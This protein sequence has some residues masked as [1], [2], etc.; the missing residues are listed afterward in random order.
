MNVNRLFALIAALFFV[1]CSSA[2]PVEE[3]RTIR[4]DEINANGDLRLPESVIPRSYE[5]DLTLIPTADQ[6][7]AIASI[8]FEVTEAQTAIYMH[9]RDLDMQVELMKDGAAIDVEIVPGVN[10]GFALASG[11]PFEPGLYRA[12][13]TY[14]A[15]L[16]DTPTGLYRVEDDEAQYL[17][18]QFQPLEA[19]SVFPGFDEPKF[20]AT[21]ETTLRVP[22]GLMAVTNTPIK[23]VENEAD[24]DVYRFAKTPPLP[25]YLVAFAVG[26]FEEA[27]A[28]EEIPGVPFRILTPQGKSHLA[29]FMLEKTPEIV[30]HQV[31]Y[32]G[33]EF[34]YA[35]L[36]VVA[37]PNFSAGAMENVGL[38]TF[39]ERLLLLDADTASPS[40]KRAAISVMAHEIAH[41]WF[42]NYVTLPWWDDLWLN[43][44]FA[45]WMALKVL[46]DLEPEL[47]GG[48]DFTRQ[49]AGLTPLDSS[50]MSRAIRQPIEDSGDVYNAFDPL[51]Y[52]KGASLLRMVEA[53]IGEDAMRSGVRTYVDANP[54]GTGST[55]ELFAALDEASGQAV[56]QTLE[57]F[58][59]QPGK[60]LL[61]VELECDDTPR[62][63]VSQQRYLPAGSSA[64]PGTPW[65]VPM[66]IRYQ[67]GRKHSVHCEV[68][69]QSS[70]SIE[71]PTKR[72]PGWI[73]PNADEAGYY[74]WSL[75]EGALPELAGP[76]RK[77]LNTHEMIGLT[78]SL[79]AL[80]DAQTID[81]LDYLKTVETLGAV[82][83]RVVFNQVLSAFYRVE[84][85]LED[86][87]P[88]RKGL[89][90]KAQKLISKRLKRL[91][92]KP[93]KDE[94]SQD[95][96][97]RPRLIR[98]SAQLADNEA[99]L[100]EIETITKR[101]L[102]RMNDVEPEIARAALIVSASTSGA[103]RWLSYKMALN[104]APTPAA[105]SAILSGL[106]GFRDP[107]IQRRTLGLLLDGTIKSQDFW[108]VFGPMFRREDTREVAWQWL[109]ENYDAV[110]EQLGAMSARSLVN[111]A[112]AFCTAD[113]KQEAVGFFESREEL[114]AGS[115]RN[116]ALAAESIDRCIE[117]RE[118]LDP[119]IKEWLK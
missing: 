61:Q 9:A 48:V 94:P 23:T 96:M 104:Q 54:H 85:T 27:V 16:D 2:P 100:K 38:V 80:L 5:L 30:A 63:Q 7:E 40:Q 68:L 28:D 33:S 10:D 117:R 105:Q 59:D 39:R 87:D 11:A 92:F 77:N 1:A 97:L 20:K 6:V 65:R 114:P 46:D 52:T 29:K 110:V 24:L 115:S 12:N 118:F 83:D 70:Q 72:C 18:T 62:V 32:F 101:F 35:K 95:A 93:R 76:H 88:L 26:P 67:D 66:C 13:F 109:T 43:E 4:H 103:D 108:T 15:P 74:V 106:S 58:L 90:K 111:I 99:T 57:S 25:T 107:D 17:F 89:Q 56:G 55:D 81:P 84:R 91:G 78:A 47:E 86:D 82:E 19:R 113:K 69:D 8:E 119:A 44:S 64:S 50:E 3:I 116:L 36:D 21:F 49:V 45:S 98:A 51:T 22:T 14:S 31:D 112:S 37:V 79:K 75:N 53:W 41:M 34:P 60:P 102:A 42:G 71:L 73:Y